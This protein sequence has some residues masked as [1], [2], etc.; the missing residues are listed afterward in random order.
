[1][2][3]KNNIMSI[4]D[5]IENT[6]GSLTGSQSNSPLSGI[7]SWV[8]QEGGLDGIINK[9]KTNGLEAIV[10]SWLGK[11][12][13]MLPVSVAQITK[14]F[15]ISS[16]SDLAGKLDLTTDKTSSLLSEYLPKVVNTISQKGSDSDLSSILDAGKDLFSKR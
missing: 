3:G 10:E 6:V 12:E 8:S 2:L 15:G 7:I 13:S 9:F 4:L 1:M 16:L 5:S 14:V 11:A